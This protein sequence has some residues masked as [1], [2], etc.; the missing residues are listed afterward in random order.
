MPPEW[1]WHCCDV[2]AAHVKELTGRDI[3]AEFGEMPRSARAAADL[4]RRLGATDL[5]GVVSRLL[6][7][8]QPAASAMR[9]DIVLVKSGRIAALGICRGEI[10][11]CA[12]NVVPI[13]RAEC[14]W[15]ISR[16][17]RSPTS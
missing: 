6:G 14:C 11:E 16:F 13:G 8:A 15:P 7:A 9:G 2:A 5:E 17:R 4:Y 3:A 10:I 1:S 12:D